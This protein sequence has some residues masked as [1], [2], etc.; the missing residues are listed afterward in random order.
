MTGSESL[1]GWSIWLCLQESCSEVGAG[2]GYNV[3]STHRQGSELASSLL[4][5]PAGPGPL[6]AL[7]AW[8]TQLWAGMSAG[9]L[10]GR[11]NLIMAA[12]SNWLHDLARDCAGLKAK[13]SPH[14]PPI[15]A[16]WE[17]AHCGWLTL[18]HSNC[19]GVE[20]IWIFITILE[21]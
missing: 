14:K 11:Y 3:F 20:Q 10:T 1:A 6:C 4:G 13:T 19:L 8:H 7:G 16:D 12:S 18:G 2:L 15:L 5:G 9:S 17:S 21:S